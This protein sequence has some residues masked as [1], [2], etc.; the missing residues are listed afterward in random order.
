MTPTD[1]LA[2]KTGFDNQFEDFSGSDLE[3]S[4]SCAW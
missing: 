1:E 2:A 4:P 3:T